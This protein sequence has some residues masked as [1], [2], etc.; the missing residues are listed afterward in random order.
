VNTWWK[1]L[2][3]L[4]LVAFTLAYAIV[5]APANGQSVADAFQY[6][7]DV[8]PTPVQNV[9]D[10][11]YAPFYGYHLGVDLPASPGTT[12][13]AVANGVVKYW[14]WVECLGD[15]V[16]IEHT[17]PDGSK[18]VSVY[19]HIV[20]EDVVLGSAVTRG[21]V[22][23]YVR[24]LPSSCGTGNHLHFGMRLGAYTTGNDCRTNEWFYPG[25][26]SLHVQ[27]CQNPPLPFLK[28]PIQDQSD[29]RHG[30][31]LAEWDRDPL[32]FIGS[33]LPPN[34]PPP[35]YRLTA[36]GIITTVSEIAGFPLPV[37]PA[38]GDSYSIYWDIDTSIQSAPNQIGDLWSGAVLR[39]GFQTG[40]SAVEYT[41]TPAGGW[42]YTNTQ[43]GST[44]YYYVQGEI[45][46]VTPTYFYGTFMA[47]SSGSAAAPTG[48]LNPTPLSKWSSGGA[49]F[50][51]CS[52]APVQC[53]VSGLTGTVVSI[54]YQA[55]N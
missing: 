4:N 36:R 51:V 22:I 21:Q 17:L 1:L 7:L 39:F 28:D 20:K 19:Y 35:T 40:S 52:V 5:S 3:G 34:P 26:T 13:H 53:P 42:V 29:P 37:H 14:H 8:M 6:P 41:A 32:A 43:A 2:R 18:R 27:S 24:E 50:S 16:N 31:I 55:I 49:G 33:N 30:A 11:Y 12:V 23:G 46:N 25:Y 38:I 54:T 48:T 10:Y 15:A 44:S 47:L 45:F 9:G